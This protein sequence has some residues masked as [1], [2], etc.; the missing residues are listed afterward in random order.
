[1]TVNNSKHFIS[2]R[3]TAGSWGWGAVHGIGQG[4]TAGG[5]KLFKKKEMIKNRNLNRKQAIA[6]SIQETKRLCL[7]SVSN[8]RIRG[9]AA[10]PLSK[11]MLCSKHLPML[12][13]QGHFFLYKIV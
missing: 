13:P 4:E 9:S 1:M 2:I 7:E 3:L 11:A 10:D 12:K 6:G 5:R 8:Q